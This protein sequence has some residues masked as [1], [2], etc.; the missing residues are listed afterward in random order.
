M[1]LT[2][3]QLSYFALPK[4]V[5]YPSVGISILY[6]GYPLRGHIIQSLRIIDS[7]LPTIGTCGTVS[8]VIPPV[9]TVPYLS[10]VSFI[11]GSVESITR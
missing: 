2:L 1:N 11:V 10:G 5:P 3:Y 4:E 7:L 8:I 9:Y 6:V